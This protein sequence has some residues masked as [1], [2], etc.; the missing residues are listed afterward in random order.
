MDDAVITVQPNGAETL[1]FSG[2]MQSQHTELGWLVEMRFAPASPALTS[3][4]VL[5]RSRSSSSGSV[6]LSAR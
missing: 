6:I 1:R 5:E 4:Q 2:K 3:E